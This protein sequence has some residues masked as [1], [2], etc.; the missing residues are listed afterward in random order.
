MKVVK[1]IFLIPWIIL[2]ILITMAREKPGT[3]IITVILLA[4][5]IKAWFF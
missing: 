3:V 2:L 4:T 5:V 1:Q